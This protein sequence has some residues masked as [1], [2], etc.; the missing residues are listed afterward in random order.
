MKQ[1]ILIFIHFHLREG[2]SS[3]LKDSYHSVLNFEKAKKSVNS[4]SGNLL[5]LTTK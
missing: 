3:F 1:L 5:S 4:F 2:L